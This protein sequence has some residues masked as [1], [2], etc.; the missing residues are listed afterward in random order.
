MP[1][2]FILKNFLET[3]TTREKLL[4]TYEVELYAHKCK[5]DQSQVIF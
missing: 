2:N 5:M 3:K 4:F 1:P